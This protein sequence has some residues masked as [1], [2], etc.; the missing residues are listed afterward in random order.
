LRGDGRALDDRLGV[1]YK[2]LDAEFLA[3]LKPRP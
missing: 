1:S 3:D 2:T